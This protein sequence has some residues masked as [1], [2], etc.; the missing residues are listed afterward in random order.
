MSKLHNNRKILYITFSILVISIFTISIAYAALNTVLKISGTAKIASSSWDIYFDNVNIESG[1]S[2]TIPSIANKTTVNFSTTLNMPGDYYKFTVD[3]VNDG[4]ID[5]MIDSIEKKPTLTIDKEKYINYEIEYENSKSIESRQLVEKNSFVRLKIKVEYR[6]DIISSELPEESTV[7]NLSFKMNYIQTDN[8]NE[9]VTIKNNG[10]SYLKIIK[11]DINT[12]GSEIC[13]DQ[14]CFY[15]I[16][17]DGN[18]VS[19]VAK[20]NLDVGYNISIEQ[21]DGEYQEKIEP[22]ANQTNKQSASAIPSFKVENN[23]YYMY[24]VE[25]FSSNR[26]WINSNTNNLLPKYGDSFPAYVYDENATIAIHANNYKSILETYG[27]NINEVRYL[28]LEDLNTLGCNLEE[29]TCSNAPDWLY[30]TTY[31]TGIASADNLLYGIISSGNVGNNSYF[32]RD[33]YGVRPVIEIP[34]SE[35]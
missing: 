34:V 3:I 6:K 10:I 35:F 22:V 31:W 2:G 11:G 30:R 15:V 17:N 25:E 13:I 19:M 27:V 12:L 18:N 32:D 21:I 8:N 1:S 5:A 7:L 16:S 28:S 24:Y 26:Y 14:E 23:N 4:T 29:L 33:G 20:Y 9:N